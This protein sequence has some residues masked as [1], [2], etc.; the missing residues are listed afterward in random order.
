MY[1]CRYNAIRAVKLNWRKIAFPTASERELA[2]NL[3]RDLLNEGWLSKAG[4]RTSDAWRMRWFTL[5]GRRIAYGADPL[6]AYPKGEIFLGHTSDGYRV[7]A[8][9]HRCSAQRT[10]VLNSASPPLN[11]GPCD[12]AHDSNGF[13]ISTPN[14]DFL[15]IATSPIERDKWIRLLEQ[16]VATPPNPQE[17]QTAAQLIRKG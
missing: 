12:D 17:N 14:R 10:S 11:G 15:L 1:I 6:D 4:P 2:E 5:E 3:T 7:T 13:T 16:I 9:V 8:S